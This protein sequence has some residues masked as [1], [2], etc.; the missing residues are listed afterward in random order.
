ML[1]LNNVE[2]TVELAGQSL[3]EWKPYINH[4]R[5][6]SRKVNSMKHLKDFNTFDSN[7]FFKD[8]LLVTREC[9][10]WQDETKGIHQGTIVTVAIDK[11][12]TV[13]Q[14]K[15]GEEFIDN[16]YEKITVKVKKD[17]KFAKNTPV[18]LVNAVAKI[19]GDYSEK[20]SV[21]ADDMLPAQPKQQ[22]SR[23]PLTKGV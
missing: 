10:D 17:V 23:Q 12:N 6:K 16:E 3:D 4:F 11:D 5:N 2:I 9:R 7:A 13:Y 14:I 15:D 19:W 20:L 22:P 21:T 18:I 1:K 8:K